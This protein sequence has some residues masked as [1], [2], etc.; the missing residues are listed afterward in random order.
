MLWFNYPRPAARGKAA[1]VLM[2]TQADRI[3][4]TGLLVRTDDPDV[5]APMVASVV[6]DA[7]ELHFLV[8]YG[9][10][11]YAS[12]MWQH[13]RYLIRRRRVG[14]VAS[15]WLLLKS[16]ASAVIHFV[17]RGRGKRTYEF[18]IDT[19][20]IVRTSDTGVTLIGWQDVNAI[21]RYRPGFMMMLKRGTLPVPMRCLKQGDIEAMRYFSA[22]VKQGALAGSR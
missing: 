5:A 15:N 16:T 20:G 4:S 13:G 9:V 21:R 18:T 22:A 10:G 2:R 19:H 8:R 11:E 1:P 7:P 14:R 17:L 3:D 12:F 6:A